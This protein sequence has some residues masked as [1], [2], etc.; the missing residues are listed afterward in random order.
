M[1]IGYQFFIKNSPNTTNYSSTAP[2]K[3]PPLSAS[4]AGPQSDTMETADKLTEGN[5]MSVIIEDNHEQ[6]HPN[7]V[8]KQVTLKSQR[9]NSI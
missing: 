3:K 2:M 7:Q 4:N 5:N 9:S 1:K 8:I 6:V